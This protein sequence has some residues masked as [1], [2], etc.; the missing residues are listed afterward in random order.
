VTQRI[1]LGLVQPRATAGNEE[2]VARFALEHGFEWIEFRDVRDHAGA[3]LP[4]SRSVLETLATSLRRHDVGISVHAP[5]A[6]LNIGAVRQDAYDTSLAAYQQSLDLARIL[7]ASHLTVHG[8]NVVMNPA[9]QSAPT[10]GEA[11]DAMERMKERT[12]AALSVLAKGASASGVTVSLENLIGFGDQ[13]K[14][15]WPREPDELLE[16][17]DRVVAQSGAR[18]CFTVDL[19]H[20][21]GFDCPPEDFVRRLRPDRVHIAHVHDNDRTGDYHWVPGKGTIDFTSFIRAY[22]EGEWSFPWLF[23]LGTLDEALEARRFIGTT[24]S[25]GV[26]LHGTRHGDP[27]VREA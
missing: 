10:K 27:S 25:G 17:R 16:C 14:R 24:D 6:G 15:R 1:C 8:G 9:S 21:H 20:L 5:H 12:T 13:K 4:S 2:T 7:G 26:S 19:G 22:T 11:R 18:V 3:D 23:E